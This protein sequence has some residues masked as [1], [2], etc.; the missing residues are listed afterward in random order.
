MNHKMFSLVLFCLVTFG[1][2]QSPPV[3]PNPADWEYFEIF[4]VLEGERVLICVNPTDGYF[5]AEVNLFT[6]T[7]SGFWGTHYHPKF[8]IEPLG[9]VAVDMPMSGSL[10]LTS[11]ARL[12]VRIVEGDEDCGCDQD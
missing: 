12:R 3:L 2:A 9:M 8:T 6:S 7:E 11:H 5:A 4:P 1:L 10:L